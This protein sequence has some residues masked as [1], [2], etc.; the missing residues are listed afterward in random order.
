M[1][2]SGLRIAIVLPDL[3]GGGVQ[4]V[5]L[6]L[7]GGLAQ[8][9]HA[10]EVLA[11][12]TAPVPTSVPPG[13]E[14]SLLAG[15][16]VPGKAV[17]LAAHIGSNEVD[18]LIAGITRANLTAVLARALAGRRPT[19]VL[20]KHLP[21]DMLSRNRVRRF[22]LKALIRATYPR[23]DAVVAVS[24]G[25]RQSL[26]DAGVR[27]RLLARIANPVITHDLVTRCGAPVDH[28]WFAVGGPKVIVAAG[29]LVEQ[30]GFDSLL[31]AFAALTATRDVRLVILGEGEA[32]RRLEVLAKE[33]GV[34][35]A[36]SMPGH[37]SDALPYMA[38]ASVFA[39][40][41]RWE[42]LPTV[43]I[44]ALAS[45]TTVVATDCPV[46]PREVL[47][48][49]ALGALVPVD[50]HEALARALAAALD[51]PRPVASER[52]AH[53]TV[54]GATDRYLRLIASARS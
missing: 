8:R 6:N 35:S 33:L 48:D 16:G 38:R 39:L 30:K 53:Y 2:A 34:A 51:H 26:K 7:A 20:T 42:G 5:L 22:V 50:D 19:T 43:L 25:T 45:G 3:G 41:S 44:E 47:E 24:E 27:A 52:L 15:R 49:G 9:G 23:A 17:R 29:R 18:V 54:E 40:S 13:V 28:P 12:S 37:V 10:V 4:R 11:M 1:S 21:L 32:R 36:V 46:G 14:V 31:R